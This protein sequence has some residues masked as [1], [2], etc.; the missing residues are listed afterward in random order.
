MMKKGTNHHSITPALQYFVVPLL[1]HSTTP[2]LRLLRK[3]IALNCKLVCLVL[4]IFIIFS[5]Q[6]CFAT[7]WA[8]I[9]GGSEHDYA[10]LNRSNF[11]VS[12]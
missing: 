2:I 9:Y 5:A 7:Q 8:K 10:P 6:N 11:D 3:A 1:Q 4:T 12:M